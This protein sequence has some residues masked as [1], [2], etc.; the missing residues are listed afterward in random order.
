MAQIHVQFRYIHD[1][2]YL[3]LKRVIYKHDSIKKQSIDPNI[4]VKARKI[5]VRRLTY[6]RRKSSCI[7]PLKHKRWEANI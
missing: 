4:K 6:D 7:L 3:H 1:K 2:K 5:K